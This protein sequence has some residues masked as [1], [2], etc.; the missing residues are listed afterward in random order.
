MSYLIKA[1]L[2]VMKII[3][4]MEYDHF[5][6]IQIMLL[7]FLL[8]PYYITSCDYECHILWDIE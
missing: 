1:M 3:L 8:I 6:K 2:C 7:D 4:L 5:I